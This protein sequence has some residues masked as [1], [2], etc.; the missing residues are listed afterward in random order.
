M[1]ATPTH[2]LEAVSLPNGTTSAVPM[3]IPN[4]EPTVNACVPSVDTSKGP[5]LTQHYAHP[6]NEMYAHAYIH[7]HKQRYE[8]EQQIEADHQATLAKVNTVQLCLW[9]QVCFLFSAIVAGAKVFSRK[10][11]LLHI[12]ALSLPALEFSFSINTSWSNSIETCG[13]YVAVA[14]GSP[15]VHWIMQELNMPISVRLLP[16]RL[17]DCRM[18]C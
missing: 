18:E 13:S 5:T 7:Q 10:V 11:K 14:E 12:C 9:V 15:Q 4:S 17:R 2:D 6:L 8:M 3:H 16:S 1:P